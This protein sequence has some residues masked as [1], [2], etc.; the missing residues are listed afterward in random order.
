MTH[1]GNMFQNQFA[2]SVGVLYRFNHKVPKP[3]KKPAPA[4]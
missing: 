4:Q 2:I 3:V 1:H